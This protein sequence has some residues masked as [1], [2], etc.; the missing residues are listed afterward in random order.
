MQQTY[1]ERIIP[2]ILHH[3]RE[4]WYNIDL[5]KKIK[6]GISQC[7]N[8]IAIEAFWKWIIRDI[9]VF[10]E[11]T[12]T[13]PYFLNLVYKEAQKFVNVERELKSSRN[14]LARPSN[15]IITSKKDKERNPFINICL[16]PPHFKP[17]VALKKRSGTWM[18]A[19]YP[20][21]GS[22]LRVSLADAIQR[23]DRMDQVRLLQPMIA[24]QKG[25]ISIVL[26]IRAQ[27]IGP[28]T[29]CILSGRGSN[30]YLT[31]I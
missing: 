14:S 28:R 31:N 19:F 1:Q 12:K 13:T 7:I 21:K 3:L 17:T 29:V 5:Y 4:W 23:M 18:R 20:F 11:L 25:P 10:I 6:M 2:S 30:F 16:N 27:V 24:L 15:K 22:P 9:G 8:S 26:F